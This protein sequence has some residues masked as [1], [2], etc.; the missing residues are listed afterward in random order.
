MRLKEIYKGPWDTKMLMQEVGGN[1]RER[2]A[3]LRRK[4]KRYR[5]W[6]I[7]PIPLGCSK[8]SWMKIHEDMILPQIEKLSASSKAA[9][10]ARIEKVGYSHKWR[11]VGQRVLV[12]RFISIFLPSF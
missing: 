9:A 8:F 2:R 6:R 3:R 11:P 1:L 12:K 7:V 5:N 10:D 4:F